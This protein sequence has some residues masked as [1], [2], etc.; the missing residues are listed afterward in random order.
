MY[1]ILWV[2]ESSVYHTMDEE[3]SVYHIMDEERNVYDI[4]HK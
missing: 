1:I 2:E 4:E 3:R